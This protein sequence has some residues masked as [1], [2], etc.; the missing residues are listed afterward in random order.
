MSLP[1]TVFR[2]PFFRSTRISQALLKYTLP[3]ESVARARGCAMFDAVAAK[4]SVDWPK[5]PDPAAVL[6]VWSIP[7]RRI[8]WSP[9]S[10]TNRLPVGS[11]A[12]AQGSTKKAL[13]AKPLSPMAAVRT[14]PAN[15]LRVASVKEIR[16]MTRWMKSGAATQPAGLTATSPILG[17]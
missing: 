11:T 3:A 6:I 9:W 8:R 7:M 17:M 4:P 5:V 2:V 14:L 1:A 13:V 16:L 15:T 10:A 12:M